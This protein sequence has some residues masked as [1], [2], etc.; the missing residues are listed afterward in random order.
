MIE[1]RSSVLELEVL[2]AD[3]A[4]ET[5]AEVDITLGE[6]L[7]AVIEPPNRPIGLLVLLFALRAPLVMLKLPAVQQDIYLLATVRTAM[8]FVHYDSDK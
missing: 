5:V 2:L 1:G 6:Q 8:L 4:P 3:V 7:E